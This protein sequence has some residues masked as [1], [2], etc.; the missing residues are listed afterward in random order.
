[1]ILSRASWLPLC[2]LRRHGPSNLV[3]PI[4]SRPWSCVQ[5]LLSL[6]LQSPG[7]VVPL[8]ELEHAVRVNVAVVG[9]L[10]HGNLVTVGRFCCFRPEGTLVHPLRFRCLGQFLCL[11]TKLPP[12]R[13]RPLHKRGLIE[14]RVLFVNALVQRIDL[15]LKRVLP[16]L[17]FLLLLPLFKPLLLLFLP[18]LVILV[19]MLPAGWAPRARSV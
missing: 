18:D 15:R 2:Q 12:P 10:D 9:R 11:Y 14:V 16:Q 7:A 4:L 8:D 3:L 19:E 13:L 1:M 6:L 5:C 17:L